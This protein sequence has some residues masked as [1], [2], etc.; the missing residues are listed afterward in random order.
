MQQSIGYL[1][2]S[3]REQGDSRNGLDAQ[4]QALKDF[5]QAHGYT[6]LNIREEVASGALGLEGRPILQKVLAQAKRERCT[7]LVSKLDRLSRDVAFI[8][9]LM[10]QRVPFVVA[11]LGPDVDPFMLHIH[12]AVAEQERRMIGERT[13]LALAQLKG[14]GVVLGNLP[15]LPRAGASGRQVQRAQAD[16]F[17]M[18]LQPT[19]ARMQREGM[20]LKAMAQE[21]NDNGTPT[22]RGGSWGA[23]TVANLLGRLDAMENEER[24]IGA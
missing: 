1:R 19:V 4:R 15:S 18:R 9:G 11:A 21:L 17:A 7:V 16:A 3:T 13:R 23:T 10:S 24:T 2:V 22:A 14:R 6:L 20:T 5:A 12:A 8:A